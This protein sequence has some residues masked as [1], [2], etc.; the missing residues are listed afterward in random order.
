MYIGQ[1]DRL[2]E[3]L[4]QKALSSADSYIISRYAYNFFAGIKKEIL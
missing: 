3:Q 2:S 4:D 1:M